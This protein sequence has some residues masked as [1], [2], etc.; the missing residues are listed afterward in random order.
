MTMILYLNYKNNI[1]KIEIVNEGGDR[2][3]KNSQ[4]LST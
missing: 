1:Y 3:Q 4:N 2:Y